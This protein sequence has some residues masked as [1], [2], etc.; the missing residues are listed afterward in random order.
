MKLSKIILENKKVVVRKQ[1][2]LSKEDVDNLAAT[3]SEK[4]Q[5][6]LD[7]ENIEILEQAVSAAIQE[8]I[9]E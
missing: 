9:K 8:L 2:N 5:D 1:L 7:T 4:L 3:I 6:Y